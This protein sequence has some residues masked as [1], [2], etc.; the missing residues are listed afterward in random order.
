MVR[1]GYAVTSI[2]VYTG[3][4]WSLARWTKKSPDELTASDLRGYLHDLRRRHV[5]ASW[6]AQHMSLFRLVWDKFQ[7]VQ[8]TAAWRG[9][10]RGR[11]LPVVLTAGEVAALMATAKT[12]SE[13]LAVSLLYGVGL[14]TGQ[15]LELRWLDIDF[16]KGGICIRDTGSETRRWV[17]LPGS[18]RSLCEFNRSRLGYSYVLAG[19]GRGNPMSPRG[20]TSMIRRLALQSGLRIIVTPSMLRDTFIAHALAQGWTFP[21]VLTAAGFRNVA[22]LQRFR[23]LLGAA[24]A[25]QDAD[26]MA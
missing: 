8:W 14:K 12:L 25:Q 23:S 20:L 3:M 18:L 26:G 16:E 22:A 15:L 6:I 2:G 11:P 1:A 13:Y 10:K 7:G 24:T 21:G 17:Q 5:S 19:R 4:L 9:P